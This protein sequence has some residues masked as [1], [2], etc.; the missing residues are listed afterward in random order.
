MRRRPV[1]IMDDMEAPHCAMGPRSVTSRVQIVRKLR[2]GADEND[3]IH[4]GAWGV[5]QLGQDGCATVMRKV[6]IDKNTDS[7]IRDNYSFLNRFYMIS[8]IVAIRSLQ[9]VALAYQRPPQRKGCS[10]E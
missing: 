3:M 2:H 10:K 5:E 4:P 6:E 8:G 9:Q 7:L 1:A